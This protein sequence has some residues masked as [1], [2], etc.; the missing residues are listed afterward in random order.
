MPNKSLPLMVTWSSPTIQSVA[1][2]GS[3]WYLFGTASGIVRKGE[4]PVR[5]SE[6]LHHWSFA[7]MSSIK[8][9]G[10]SRKRALRPRSCGARRQLF[11]GEYYL[12]YAFS[13]F[14]KNTSGIALATNK[15]LNPASPDFKWID[16]GLVIQSKVEDDF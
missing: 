3:T 2:D 5:C 10:G 15:T 8:S 11:P 16:H 7:A 12:Y 1:K 9:Q 14:G 4:L 13:I 6:D